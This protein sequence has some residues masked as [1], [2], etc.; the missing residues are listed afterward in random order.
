MAVR[1]EEDGG[2][3]VAAWYSEGDEVGRG[4]RYLYQISPR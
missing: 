1:V 3:G 4:D 2:E